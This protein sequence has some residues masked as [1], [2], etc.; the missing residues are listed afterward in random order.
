MTWLL[1]FIGGGL[2]ASLRL[3]MA[4]ALPRAADGFPWA[5]LGANIL[6]CLAIGALMP[7]MAK[8]PMRVFWIV[9]LLGGFTTFSA[10]SLETMQLLETR[11]ILALTYVLASVGLGLTACWLGMRIYA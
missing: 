3:G 8:E 9:G 1:V 11:P 6:G 4:Q 7:L 5:T 2:G 10:F